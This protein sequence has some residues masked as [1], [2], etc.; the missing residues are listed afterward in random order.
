MTI[1]Y[2]PN[3]LLDEV[4]EIRGLKNDAALARDFNVAPPVISKI[5]HNRL[6]VGPSFVLK[7]IEIAGMTAPSVRE[8]IGG[9]A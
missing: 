8:F 1:T 4:I 2:D 6:M 9:A 7:C 3:G 5:R